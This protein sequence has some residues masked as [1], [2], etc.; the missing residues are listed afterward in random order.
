MIRHT[1]VFTLK[2]SKN[3]QQEKNFLDDALRL[4]N[5]SSVNNFERLKQI[6]PKNT[7]TFGFSMEFESKEGYDFLQQSSRSRGFCS[8]AVDSGGLKFS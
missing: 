7:F 6:S 5:I 3:S 8:E 1:V 4:A 2:H